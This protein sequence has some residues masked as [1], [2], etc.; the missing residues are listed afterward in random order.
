MD[1]RYFVS[2]DSGMLASQAAIELQ[3]GRKGDSV[4][5]RAVRKLSLLIRDAA[6]RNNLSINF[7][8]YNTALEFTDSLK[9]VDDLRRYILSISEEMRNA[10]SASPERLEFIRD[11]SLNLAR[12]ICANVVSNRIRLSA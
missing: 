3:L 5:Y 8:L 2:A 1:Y 9:N 7:L 12:Y 10:E 4:E 11:F 6:Q